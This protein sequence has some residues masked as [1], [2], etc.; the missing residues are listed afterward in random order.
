MTMNLQSIRQMEARAARTWPAEESSLWQGW[1]LRASGGVTKRANSVL[2]A[3]E[4]PLGEAGW[5]EEIEAF[6]RER[7]LPPT[8]HVTD[9]SPASLD[10]LLAS[11]G[12]E[13]E[14]PC[15]VMTAMTTDVQKA[16]ESTHFKRGGSGRVRVIVQSRADEAWIHNFV[17][18]EQF[19]EERLPFY[20]GLCERMP[21]GSRF[22]TLLHNDA[23]A[24]IAT[25]VGEDGWG[26]IINVA[27]DE[28]LRGRGLGT[29]LMHALGCE[30]AAN[31]I[32]R[33]YLQVVANN[34]PAYRMY[35]KLGFSPA[36]RFHYRVKH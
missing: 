33:L 9:G 25:L 22:F 7:S 20:R 5:L 28:T 18:L 3:G 30:A 19:P 17:R 27:V 11:Q 13:K 4:G 2:T 35:R 15:E 23:P 10:E 34:E 26:G 16:A 21:E 36:Y 24:A 1:L 31:Q 32:D 12:Y 6:Y 8:F 14:F 29:V